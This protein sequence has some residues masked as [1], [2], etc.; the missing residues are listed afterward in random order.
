LRISDT[1][2]T[3]SSFKCMDR[4]PKG[5]EISKNPGEV[6]TGQ[7]EGLASREL[8]PAPDR[9]PAFRFDYDRK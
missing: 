2:S 5:R 3:L 7:T 4:A 6:G 9:E 1:C 8:E